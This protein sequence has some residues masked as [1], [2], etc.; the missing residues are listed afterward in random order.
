MLL[1]WAIDL[2]GMAISQGYTLYT[3]PEH[4]TTTRRLNLS[5]AIR[6]TVVWIGQFLWEPS[7]SIDG[8]CCWCCS[9][10]LST[11]TIYCP[12]LSR[13]VC[14]IGRSFCNV[15]ASG[16]YWAIGGIEWT[17]TIQNTGQDIAANQLH[18]HEKRQTLQA[19]R[20]VHCCGSV[21]WTLPALS[22]FFFCNDDDAREFP[23]FFYNTI[24]CPPIDKSFQLLL[25][26]LLSLLI[27]RRFHDI[28]GDIENPSFAT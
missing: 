21:Q 2:S 16:R 10:C 23:S 9:G 25:Q 12:V 15:D 3:P 22:L 27:P 13:V 24:Y 5:I 17:A 14:R 7:G 11:S 19:G 26:V 6:H 8:S 4:A 28:G 1:F 18:H 20:Q